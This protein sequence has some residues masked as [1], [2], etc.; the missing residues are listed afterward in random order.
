L[1]WVTDTIRNPEL[2][3]EARQAALDRLSQNPKMISHAAEDLAHMVLHDDNPDLRVRA[4]KCIC[5][6]RDA[7]A[8]AVRSFVDEA[9]KPGGEQRGRAAQSLGAM[10][11][12]SSELVQRAVVEITTRNGPENINDLKLLMQEGQDMFAEELKRDPQLQSELQKAL[13]SGWD[14]VVQESEVDALRKTYEAQVVNSDQPSPQV[15]FEFACL[16]VS[17]PKRANIR[18]GVELLEELLTAGFHRAEVLHHLALTHLKLGQYVRAKEQVDV[19]L[20]LQPRNSMARLLA[21]LVLDRASHDGPHHQEI[22]P[23]L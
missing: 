7:S 3:A 4:Q 16:L 19:L 14:A 20:N 13:A 21:S 17:S 1:P 8:V 2:S 9:L 23:N 22:E 18:E 5:R 12:V 6:R 10:E 11:N 15:Q